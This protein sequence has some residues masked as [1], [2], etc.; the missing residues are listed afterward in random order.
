MIVIPLQAAIAAGMIMLGVF[1]VLIILFLLIPIPLYKLLKSWYL[2][3]NP[4]KVPSTIMKLG[5]IAIAYLMAG[6]VIF[7][8]G[9]ILLLMFSGVRFD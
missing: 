3:V 5:F 9:G 2:R 1:C 6:I 8:L 7:I 4:D